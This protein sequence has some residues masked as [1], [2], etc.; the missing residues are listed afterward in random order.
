MC[1]KMSKKEIAEIGKTVGG[2]IRR[3][4]SGYRPI[5][6]AWYYQILYDVSRVISVTK[7]TI[8]RKIRG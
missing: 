6:K 8:I 7:M 5:S 1:V 2:E 3:V 4:K